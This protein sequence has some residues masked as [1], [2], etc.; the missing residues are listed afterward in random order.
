MVDRLQSS[1]NGEIHEPYILCIYKKNFIREIILGKERILFIQYL[2]Y[3]LH[4]F[5]TNNK[6]FPVDNSYKKGTPK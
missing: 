5:K 6:Y 2:Q 4:P 3:F 1:E